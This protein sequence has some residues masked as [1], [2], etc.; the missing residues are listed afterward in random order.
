MGYVIL[1]ALLVATLRKRSFCCVVVLIIAMM[2]Q[3]VDLGVLRDKVYAKTSAPSR[4]DL[5]PWESIVRDVDEICVYPAWGCPEV[6]PDM[7][8]FFQ[9]V[10]ARYDK[11]ISTGYAS[12]PKLNLCRDK[13]GFFEEEFTERRLYIMPADYK[14]VP[15]GFRTA[16]Q[17]GQCVECQEVAVCKP[18]ARQEDWIASGLQVFPVA[19]HRYVSEPH[20]LGRRLDFN[21]PPV[22]QYLGPGWSGQ[23][24]W[25]TW[26]EGPHAEIRLPLDQDS[27]IG[28]YELYLK[29]RLIEPGKQSVRVLL[30][31]YQIG[32]FGPYPE[33]A[34]RP[35]VQSEARFFL[36]GKAVQ[37][38]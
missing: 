19:S 4:G 37:A 30:N 11:L 2:L 24:S 26:T 17:R 9:R 25:G 32:A 29:F 1:F 35:V 38:A 16:M 28:H 36:S 13:N 15:S 14:Y 18:G 33:A 23:E 34:G 8:M 22:G 12:R 6:H 3:W 27:A 20:V 5:I 10:A 7:Y 21:Q 31:G